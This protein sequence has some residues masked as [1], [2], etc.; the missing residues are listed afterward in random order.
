MKSPRTGKRCPWL[1]ATHPAFLSSAAGWLGYLDRGHNVGRKSRTKR[2]QRAALTLHPPGPEHV[3]RAALHGKRRLRLLTAWLLLGCLITIGG[4]YAHFGQPARVKV[5]AKL[6]S[7]ESLHLSYGGS[8]SK[9]IS[10]IC[11]CW[12]E[13]A[14]ETWRGVTFA[15]RRLTV[16][17]SGPAPL[18]AYVVTAPWPADMYSGGPWMALPVKSFGPVASSFDPLG[19]LEQFK[20]QA[21]PQLPP[22]KI[23]TNVQYAILVTDRPL[24]IRLFGD[25]PIGAWIPM[26]SSTISITPQLTMF[27]S[28]SNTVELKESY[29]QIVTGIPRRPKGTG[30]YD[31]ME[32]DAE[33]SNAEL[34]SL[35]LIGK[36][37][38]MWSDSP[39]AS[40]WLSET[41]MTTLKD[42][43]EGSAVGLVMDP[44]FSARITVIPTSHE[45]LSRFSEIEKDQMLPQPEDWLSVSEIGSISVRLE[46]TLSELQEF[47]K[48]AERL[49]KN[50]NVGYVPVEYPLT[51]WVAASG[52][53]LFMY[54]A[55]QMNFRY[56][57]SPPSRGFNVFGQMAY[58]RFDGAI[59]SVVL[60]SRS[61]DIPAPSVL[62]FRDLDSFK[63]A[64]GI[65]PVA[66]RGASEGLDTSVMFSG[67]SEAWANGELLTRVADRFSW[68]IGFLVLIIGIVQMIAA[69]LVIANDIFAG[70]SGT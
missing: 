53:D 16:S 14:A 4:A 68:S 65:I 7:F 62:E 42:G 18:T 39:N 63:A 11:G 49:K 40:V 5:G 37:T 45:A 48:L 22:K 44:V 67:V 29:Q 61:V 15:A 24:H 12:K 60:G 56:P 70:R 23:I 50:D 13:Q 32:P 57:P 17:R 46:R 19:V 54:K 41:D 35:D 28:S 2:H 43:K 66:V 34:P 21:M 3:A 59:G 27:P 9:H 55:K 64:R 1:P 36:R 25:T 30:Q 33:Q 31:Y 51:G 69:F 10:P 52:E 26:G 58:L 6:A 47:D 20:A 38:V 8:T